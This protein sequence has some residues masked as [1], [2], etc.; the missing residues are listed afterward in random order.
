MISE[1]NELQTIKQM[2]DE[3]GIDKQRVYRYIRKNHINAV[4]Q[5]CGVMYY[6]EVVK[7][8]IMKHFFK[9]EPHHEVH[10]DVHQTASNDVITVSFDAVIDVLKSEL[11]I[12]N[13]QIQELNARLAESNAALVVAQQS[14]QTA[15]ALHAGTI[16][17]QLID[18][19]METDDARAVGFFARIFRRKN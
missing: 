12:K 11:E 8:L 3:F 17:K 9:N 13:K 15:Q 2:A 4:H 10:H 6:D 1:K 14:A 7:T 16:Q 5:K 19:S 18:G